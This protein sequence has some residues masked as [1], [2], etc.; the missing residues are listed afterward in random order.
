MEHI[1]RL[2]CLGICLYP[3]EL[4]LIH[5]YQLKNKLIYYPN[6]EPDRSIPNRGK[7]CYLPFFNNKKILIICPF[8][9]I[10][11]ERAT[12]EIF[13]GVWAKT[14]K[15]WFYPKAVDALEFPYGFAKETQEKY[16]TALNLYE[17]IIIEIEK[18]DFDIALIGAAG[19]AIPIASYIQSMGKI[20]IDLGGALQFFFGVF[21][22]RWGAF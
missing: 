12:K 15:K 22:K 2:D 6:Q 1:R 20:G 14:G 5:Y 9:G 8:A 13:E 10:L 17:Y 4:E 18:R 11:K 21:G 3:G 19:L 16:A 7:E